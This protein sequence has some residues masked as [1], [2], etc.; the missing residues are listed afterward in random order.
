MCV[1]RFR[2]ESAKGDLH[3]DLLMKQVEMHLM[4]VEV[5]V[6]VHLESVM[7]SKEE[8]V[9]A[10]THADIHMMVQVV[11]IILEDIQPLAHPDL[12]EFVMH[13]KE[14]NVI[15]VTP[16]VL[17]MMKVVLAQV[18]VVVDLGGLLITLDLMVVDL[19]L[20]V[21]VTHFREASVIEEKVAALAMKVVE[22]LDILVVTKHHHTHPDL[23][24]LVVVFVMLSREASVPEVTDA[25]SLMKVAKALRH[26]TEVALLDG[27]FA[28]HFNVESV[29]VEMVA[30]FL[31][32]QAGLGRRLVT[33]LLT[34]SV[35]MDVK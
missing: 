34:K 25:D 4:V 1:T 31:M 35:L 23:L 24:A 19:V 9:N 20:V 6:E 13:F 21:F 26:I 29:L 17:P 7:H 3:V 8:S 2:E 18:A 15:V 12:L 28:T 11:V 14:V 27:V 16:A 5:L 32:T 30:V 10:L 33:Q 22:M